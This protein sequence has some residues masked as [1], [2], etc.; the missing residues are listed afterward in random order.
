MGTDKETLEWLQGHWVDVNGETTLDFDGDRMTVTSPWDEEIYQVKITGESLKYIKNTAPAGYDDGFGMMS[1]IWI[2]S[3]GTLSAGDMVLDAKGHE[4]RFVREENLAGELEITIKDWELPK[5]IESDEIVS[6]HLDFSNTATYYDIPAGGPWYGGWY[7]IEVE[8][9]GE[10][11]YTLSLRGMGESYVIVQYDGAVSEDYVKG[12]AAL[13]QEQK[14]AE[15]NGWWREN[16]EDFP[17]WSVH[18]EYASGEE[19]LMEASGRAALEC[20]FSIYAFLA[21]ADREAGFAEKQP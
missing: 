13:V 19:I 15:N 1:A 10:G 14:L 20:P 17:S 6:F 8:Q 9:K 3:D 5:T 7:T 11:E 21:Y 2:Q 16:N 18:I 12:L 4:Y